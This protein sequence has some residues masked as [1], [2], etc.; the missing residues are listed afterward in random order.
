MDRGT[1]TRLNWRRPPAWAIL[2]AIV[3]LSTAIR[4]WAGNKIGG[5]WIMPDEAIYASV[6]QS[7]YRSAE[8]SVLGQPAYYSLLYP[9]LAGP[10]LVVGDL[11]RGY[12]ALKLLQALVMSLTAVPVYLWGRT[13][14]SQSWALVAATL[15]L[16]G[17][18]LIFS[19]LIMTEVAFYPVLVLAAWAI[20]RAF[21][22]PTLGRQAVLVAA[23]AAAAGTRLQ[24]M[25]LVPVF[26][27][28]LPLKALFDR[29]LR[30]IRSFVPTLAGLA[31]L[32][33]AWAVFRLKDGGPWT[34]LLGS[35]QAAGEKT[36]DPVGV[37]KFISYHF[38]DVLILTAVFPLC[39]VALLVIE[40]ALSRERLEPVRA[41]LAVTVALVAWLVVEVG[42]FASQNVKRLAERDLIGLAPLLFL[43]FCIWLHRGGP[44]P[45]LRTAVV[46]VIL[47]LPLL[48]LP[49]DKLIV[50]EALTDAFT[51]VPLYW[52]VENGRGDLLELAVYGGAGVAMALFVLLPRRALVVLPVLVFAGLAAASITASREVTERANYDQTYLLGAK[53]DWVD[54]AADGTVAYLY[55]GESYWNGVWQ[56]LFWNEKLKRIYTRYP[57]TVPGPLPQHPTTTQA[58]GLL[59]L[60]DGRPVPERYVIASTDQELIGE[61]VADIVQKGLE[62]AGLVL[63]RVE[64]PLRLSS[65]RSGVRGDGDMHEP[66][67]IQAYGCG[68]G[69]FRLQLIAKAS[70][71]VSVKLNGELYETLTFSSPD[72][73]WG[74]EISAGTRSKDEICSLEVSGNSLLG[75]T[76]FEFVRV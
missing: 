2:A 55:S 43:G 15:S 41:Y 53:R 9:L 18:A 25:V 36:Y 71:R 37:A 61:P 28:A 13:L 70:T 75:S 8:L 30:I 22:R 56:Q 11:D 16:A 74:A 73:T 44:R 63:W 64:N 32:A 76:V 23:I 24:A 6:A 17:P 39:A 5:L 14:M 60:R 46:A 51:V 1:A 42:V 54:D 47:L 67:R 69:F 4:F 20:A 66:G 12:V 45:R 34:R 68:E 49:L 7:L 62:H 65:V 3:G 50:G 38:A 33:L 48:A 57:A 27:S 26:L 58:D 40:A 59:L 19:G 10:A 21:E 35:Y 31:G 29:S 52:L 72:E